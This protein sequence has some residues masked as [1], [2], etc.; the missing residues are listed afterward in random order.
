[1]KREKKK[2]TDLL[3]DREGTTMVEVLVAILI[4]MIVMAMFSKV[5]TASVTLY[6]KSAAVI[7][8]T[9]HFNEVYYKKDSIDSR[10]TL[11]GVGFRLKLEGGTVIS[12]PKGEVK[13]FTDSETGFVRYSIESKDE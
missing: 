6:H 2:I 5:V 10:Q 9:E 1:M 7:E 13:K 4:V 8:N 11:S 12:L 3:R